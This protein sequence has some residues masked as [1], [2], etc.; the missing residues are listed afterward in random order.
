MECWHYTNFKWLYFHTAWGYRHMVRHA[1]SPICIAHADMTLTWSKVN[2]KVTDLLKFQ[3]LH[4][5]TSI[6]CTILAWSSKMMVDYYSFLEPDFWISPSWRSRDFQVGKMLI[7]PES[8]GFISALPE[9]RSLWLWLQ[10]GHNKLCMLVAMTVSP[11]MAIFAMSVVLLNVQTCTLNN[12]KFTDY[13][14]SCCNFVLSLV[15]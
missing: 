5:S 2:I 10:V 3:K 8:T 4:F 6:S 11:P 15:Q 9:A 1:G 7:L 14:Y 12:S 13:F